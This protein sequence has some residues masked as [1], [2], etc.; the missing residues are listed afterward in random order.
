MSFPS[1]ACDCQT[2]PGSTCECGCQHEPSEQTR[3]C[4]CGDGC[5]CGEHCTCG[6]ACTCA[7]DSGANMHQA[8]CR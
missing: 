3:S 4:Q 6:D 1:N 2:C 7:P 8:H 5:A